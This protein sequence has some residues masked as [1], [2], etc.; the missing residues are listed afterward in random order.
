[1][2]LLKSIILLVLIISPI[3]SGQ[4]EIPEKPESWVSD[5]AGVLSVTEKE[6]LNVMLRSLEQRSS[7]QIYIAIFNKLPQNYYLE[8][9]AVKLFEKWRPGLEKQDN[10]ILIVVFIEDRKIRIEVGYGLED[11][12]TDA[13]SGVLINQYI[14]PQFRNGNYFQGL[15]DALD[16]LIPAVEGKYKIPVEKKSEK[17]I[18]FALIVIIIIF[19]VMIIRRFGGNR[20]TGF[21]T[22]RR[23]RYSSAPYIFGG[24]GGGS[25][26]GGSFGGGGFSGG[27]G[28]L[29]GG[30][31]ASGGW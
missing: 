6:D 21:G 14:K 11:V 28:G 16:V 18:P 27:F 5:Y 7:N 30:G 12:V 13:Q 31:G 29:S 23:G 19:L 22:K 15:K 26:G 9:F 17:E 2:K 3:V 24:F 1:M 20:P 25:S 8:D 10:G 4:T